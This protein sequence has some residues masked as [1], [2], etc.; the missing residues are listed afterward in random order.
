MVFLVM[1]SL[2]KSAIRAHPEMGKFGEGR[3]RVL[4]GI[5]LLSLSAMSVA[6][7]PTPLEER[8]IEFLIAQIENLQNAQF[9]RNGT[10][11]DAKAAADHLRLKLKNAGSR[12]ATAEDFI[13]LCASVSSLSGQPYQIRFSDGRVVSSEAFLRQRLAELQL[14]ESVN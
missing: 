2:A 11:Y 5:L 1:C 12:V 3:V 13:R 10:A 9:I 8:R 7:G 4:T 14:R 6:A